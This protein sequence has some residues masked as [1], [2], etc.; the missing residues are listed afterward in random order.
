MTEC[1]GRDTLVLKPVNAPHAQL[2]ITVGDIIPEA[3]GGAAGIAT[4]SSLTSTRRLV[5]IST[6]S[7][8]TLL[9][10]QS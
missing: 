6:T 10:S 2:T 4:A 3:R 8:L 7:D 1:S 9:S 5:R